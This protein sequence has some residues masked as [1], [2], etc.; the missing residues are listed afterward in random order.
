MKTTR[1]NA[2]PSADDIA[3][4]ADEGHSV[5]KHFTNRGKMMPPMLPIQRVNVDF[6]EPMLKELDREARELNISRQ[7]VI[8]TLLRRALDERNLAGRREVSR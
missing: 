6:T 4:L 3:K 7:A 5:S 2:V 8:K 1:K